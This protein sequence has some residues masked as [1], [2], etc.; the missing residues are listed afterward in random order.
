M[1]HC[2]KSEKNE[3]SIWAKIWAIAE[4]YIPGWSHGPDPQFISHETAC[5]L[6]TTDQDAHIAITIYYSNREPGASINLSCQHDV[7]GIYGS[8]TWQSLNR[9]LPI[10]IFASLIKSNILIIFQHTRLDSRQA[11]NTL[12]STV[13]FPINP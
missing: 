10:P 11:E 5:I 1:P 4:G 13:A 3:K 8:M 9:S 6:N 2:I 7:P 12:L